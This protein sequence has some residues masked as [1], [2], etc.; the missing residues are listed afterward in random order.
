[1]IATRFTI[2]FLV[3]PFRGYRILTNFF[4]SIVLI[5]VG[6]FLRCLF[7]FF[8][9][10]FIGQRYR[11]QSRCCLFARFVVLRWLGSVFFSLLVPIRFLFLWRSH[12]CEKDS[13]N[14]VWSCKV[15]KKFLGIFQ[16]M[17]K[18]LGLEC[19]SIPWTAS[20]CFLFPGWTMH[21]EELCRVQ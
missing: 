21:L 3:Y 5:P 8:Y 12:G 17:R 1:M 15:Q 6:S 11:F 16:R 9:S 4:L 19:F 10:F 2:P 18:S 7:I 14:I 13:H 20:F